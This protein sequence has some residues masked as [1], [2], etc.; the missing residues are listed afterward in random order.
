MK[1]LFGDE[2]AIGVGDVNRTRAEQNRRAPSGE[3]GDIRGKGRDHRL[4]AGNGAQFDERNFQDE[5]SLRQPGN[6]GGDLR[7]D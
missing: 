2:L 1:L 6:G 5:L 7:T 3:C 4:N